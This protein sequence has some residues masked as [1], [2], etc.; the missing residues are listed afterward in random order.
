MGQVLTQELTARWVTHPPS[1]Q[2]NR[3]RSLTREASAC[4]APAASTVDDHPQRDLRRLA[5]SIA[6][7]RPAERKTIRA[8]YS[9]DSSVH[10]SESRNKRPRARSCE[11]FWTTV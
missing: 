8:E 2:R 10:V 3:P 5:T 11:P 7:Y 9:K 4:P 1:S 6:S